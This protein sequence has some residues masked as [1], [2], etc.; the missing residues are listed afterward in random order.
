MTWS[1]FFFTI[2]QRMLETQWTGLCSTLWDIFYHFIKCSL[3][4]IYPVF[5]LLLRQGK[6]E[7][8]T[9]CFPQHYVRRSLRFHLFKVQRSLFCSIPWERNTF[10]QAMTALLSQ[11]HHSLKK[12]NFPVLLSKHHDQTFLEIP[13]LI[14]HIVI[15]S[16]SGWFMLQSLKKL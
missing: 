2:S 5:M 6:N 10:H 12:D 9:N 8:I 4:H 3:L 1:I 13:D 7:N 11:T 16:S 14:P 15:Y